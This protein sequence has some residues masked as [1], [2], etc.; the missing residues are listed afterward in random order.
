MLDVNGALR[1]TV[2]TGLVRHLL[3]AIS[4]MGPTNYLLIGVKSGS[5]PDTF[6]RPRT[7]V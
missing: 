6:V 4:I 5:V 1:A 3:W 2:T 7:C